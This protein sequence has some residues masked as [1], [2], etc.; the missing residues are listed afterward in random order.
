MSVLRSKMP[1]AGAEPNGRVSDEVMSLT[2]LVRSQL[3]PR[4]SSKCSASYNAAKHNTADELQD[5]ERRCGE[6]Q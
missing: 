4:L 1:C 5:S 6:R 3:E 2:A